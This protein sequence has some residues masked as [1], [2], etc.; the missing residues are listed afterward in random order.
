MPPEVMDA[1]ADPST[2][3]GTDQ[4]GTDAATSAETLKPDQAAQ[5]T[6]PPFH[7]HP[8]FQELIGKNRQLESVVSRLSQQ[9]AGLQRGRDGDQTPPEYVEAAE[10][11]FSK[12]LPAHPKL[13]ALLELAERAPALTQSV[14]SLTTAQ[15]NGLLQ[16]G[17]SQIATLSQTSKLPSDENS[18]NLIE[19]MVAG[20]IRRLPDGE[21]RF[22]RGD[23]A[24]VKEAFEQV[25]KNFLSH[26]RREASAQLAQTKQK[27]SRLPP[28][29]R[30]GVP[31]SEGDL[32]LEPGKERDFTAALHKKALALLETGE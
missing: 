29:P 15:R 5:D 9:L 19:E 30:G 8:R 11:L 24:I 3:T 18:L 6:P 23:L 7:E 21:A 20:T 10:A 16:A 22:L 12:V 27:T 28:A 17:R 31:G 4:T 32:K 25:E 2:A 13:R 26:L 1:M 14:E